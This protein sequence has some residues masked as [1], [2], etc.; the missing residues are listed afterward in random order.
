MRCIKLLL[1]ILCSSSAPRFL[2][3]IN[4]ELGYGGRGHFESATDLADLRIHAVGR[5]GLEREEEVTGKLDVVVHPTT[6]KV[7]VGIGK[8]LMIEGY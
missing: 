3:R 8:V 7:K 6:G 4:W 5:F 1:R 2:G